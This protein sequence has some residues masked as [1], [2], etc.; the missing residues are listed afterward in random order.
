MSREVSSRLIEFFLE[1]PTSEFTQSTLIKKLK[2]SKV[3]V[4]RWLKQLLKNEI[5]KKNIDGIRIGYKLNEGN[6]IVKQLKVLRT[7]SMLYPLFRDRN[8]EI[9]IFG[10][11][12]IGE[13]DEKSDI[14]MLI[15][16]RQTED[17][18]KKIVFVEKNIKKKI[19]AVFYTPVE[20]SKVA[21]EDPA[22][23]EM[24]EKTKINLI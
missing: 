10:S 22:F 23:Y 20:W 4:S 12:A 14:D 7:I 16:T 13:D 5:I 8:E 18:L 17:S 11:S 24:V 2:L 21:R 3:S 19:H 9:F 6:P 1:N 15:M